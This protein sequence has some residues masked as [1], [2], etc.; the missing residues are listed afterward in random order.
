MITISICM[1][2]KNEEQV[3]SRCLDS[4]DGIADELIIV[5]TG[6]TDNTHE[7][8]SRYTDQI[9]PF[10][11]INDFSAARNFSFSKATMDYIYCAD[12]DEILD[13]EEH[14][15][16]LALKQV[17]DPSVEI[18]Q[19]LY[20]NQ[21]AFNTVYNFDEELRPKLYR[22]SS[23]FRFEGAVHEAVASDES[24]VIYDSDIKIRHCPVAHHGKRDLDL[25]F[26]TYIKMGK[27]REERI[28]KRLHT[29]L[30]RE[31]F[32]CGAP[33]DF[34]KASP[35]FLDSVNDPERDQNALLEAC[36]VL[37]HVSR[38]KEDLPQFLKYSLKAIAM[39]GCS[40]AFYELGC[41]YTSVHDYEEAAIWY[42]NAA[43]EGS[44]IL[45]IQYCTTLPLQALVATYEQLNMPE[46]ADLYRH[47]LN[48]F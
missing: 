23:G 37:M 45:N 47:K 16:L 7:V 46:Q 40:E 19:M 39:E 10:Q 33:E 44:S 28:P 25:F 3:L 9:Y 12:A 18:V 13:P 4:L 34:L 5:D 29:Q 27:L 11:W 2:V 32:V 41:Y 17:L 14:D 38:L 22:R 31:L 15:K 20:T 26:Q 24:T 43:Y 8:A 36:A 30:A 48:E 21:L 35:I 42:Y 6:S 1:I